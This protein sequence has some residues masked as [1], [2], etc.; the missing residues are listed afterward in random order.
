MKNLRIT[1]IIPKQKVY[2]SSLWILVNPYALFA[3][4]I[5]ESNTPFYAEYSKKR[6]P[7][8]AQQLY[9]M[10]YLKKNE[11]IIPE[12]LAKELD[13]KIG[14]KISIK[15]T[16]SGKL[17]IDYLSLYEKKPKKFIKYFTEQ[18][19]SNKK[20]ILQELLDFDKTNEQ[21]ISW[22]NKNYPDLIREVGLGS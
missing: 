10:E 21:V 7:I 14:D 19:D 11:V 5:S 15:V 4:W 22:L 20:K 18:P 16:L 9:Y 2:L 8:K 17:G 3:T 12:T 1:N 6:V 13:A